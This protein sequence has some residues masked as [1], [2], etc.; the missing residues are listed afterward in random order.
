MSNQIQERG[1]AP[2]ASIPA[3]A[4]NKSSA[5]YSRV[6]GNARYAKTAE[7]RKRRKGVVRTVVLSVVA[8]VAIALGVAAASAV[9]FYNSIGERLGSG[10]SEETRAVLA[11]QQASAQQLVSNWTDTSPF[12][13]LLLGTDATTW[14]MN[15]TEGGYGASESAYRT[16]T[17]ILARVDPGNHKL[18]LVSIHRD[19]LFPFSWGWDKIN[20]A[21]PYGGVPLTIQTISQFAGV[22][23]SHYAQVNLEGFYAIVDV[24]GGVE[25]DVPYEINDYEY[26]GGHLDAGLQTLNGWQAEIFVRSRHAYDDIGDGDRYR[27]A[28]QRLFLAAVLKELLAS[29]PVDMVNTI[30]VMADYVNTDLTLD[31]IVN[32][33]LAMRGLDVENDIYSTM[34]PTTASYENGGWYEYSNDE[35]WAYMMSQVDAG[36]KP[37][38]DTAYRSVTD[39]INSSNYGTIPLDAS[40][41]RVVVRN[42]SGDPARAAQVVT[43][44]QAAGWAAE[45]GGMANV[46]LENSSVVY[47][48]DLAA[49]AA[50]SVGVTLGI[51]PE[52]AGN[53]WMMEGDIMVVVGA[54]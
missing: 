17:I 33:A 22:P 37:D 41:A 51:A 1:G 35:Y 26:L 18:A 7:D 49:T 30:N 25:I 45:D 5:P 10:V 13:M 12:Y 40:T 16:D 32:L 6:S 19:T 29:S 52:H 54:A 39:D 21:Y 23:I 44:L 28:H 11:D 53:T 46:Y 2:L 24:L 4:I 42:A 31:Q 47:E 15:G 48:K 43:A 36:L 38:I 34:N 3:A 14:R 20:A 50:A 8:V 9:S 27:A